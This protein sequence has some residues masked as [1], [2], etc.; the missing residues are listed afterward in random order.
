MSTVRERE[1]EILKKAP[2]RERA[3]IL[4]DA[5][6]DAIGSLEDAADLASDLDL[7]WES[8]ELKKIANTMILDPEGV[9]YTLSLMSGYDGGCEEPTDEA[10]AASAARISTRTAK[11]APESDEYIRAVSSIP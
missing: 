1:L 7:E 6:T 5:V 11:S 2:E 8:P 3:R 9:Q 4:F 10:P